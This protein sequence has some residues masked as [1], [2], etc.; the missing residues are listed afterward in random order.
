MTAETIL[1]VFEP[2]E[3][4]V[5]HSAVLVAMTGSR[6]FLEDALVRFTGL[7][8]KQRAELGITNTYLLLDA[9]LSSART[10]VFAPH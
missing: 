9:Q 6:D 2:P 10:R 4:R 8:A 3:A 5:A 7:K 1:D